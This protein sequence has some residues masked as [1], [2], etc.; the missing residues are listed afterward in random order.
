ML[1]ALAALPF[2]Q[3]FVALW[4]IVMA[5]SNATYW[6]GRGAIEADKEVRQHGH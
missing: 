5:R 4:V 6:L 1:D 3:A 2:W